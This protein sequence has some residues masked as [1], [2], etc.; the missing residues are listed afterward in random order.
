[1]VT[2]VSSWFALPSLRYNTTRQQTAIGFWNG[3]LK[4]SHAVL[5]DVP[6]ITVGELNR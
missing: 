3:L 6:H 5:E 2:V 1:M 4:R